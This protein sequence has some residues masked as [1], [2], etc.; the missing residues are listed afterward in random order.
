MECHYK[1]PCHPADM[2]SNSAKL[3]ENT[4]HLRVHM[5]EIIAQLSAMFSQA[6]IDNKTYVDVN[7]KN[8]IIGFDTSELFGI[9]LDAC[10]GRKVKLGE[11][12]TV[13]WLKMKI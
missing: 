13:N 12:K 5:I 9:P 4:R 1:F 11:M 10:R 7:D 8:R 6:D 3:S 2:F